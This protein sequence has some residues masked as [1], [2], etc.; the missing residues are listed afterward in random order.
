MLNL[1]RA[2]CSVILGLSAVLNST[3][4]VNKKFVA[5]KDN[6]SVWLN[7]VEDCEKNY[8]HRKC[9]HHTEENI[10]N[11]NRNTNTFNNGTIIYK[12]KILKEIELKLYIKLL[13]SVALNHNIPKNKNF[14]RR[15]TKW[16]TLTL[17][18]I[19]HKGCFKK[20][21]SGRIAQYMSN[22]VPSKRHIAKE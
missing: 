12:L 2:L 21:E 3:L 16:H 20:E 18:T 22:S 13:Y 17:L 9:K 15:M 4:Q 14:R 1:L 11:G 5:L 10:T 19:F 7:T 8:T 6:N